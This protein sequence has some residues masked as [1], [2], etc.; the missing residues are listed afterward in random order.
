MEPANAVVTFVA[1]LAKSKRF[2]RDVQKSAPV[3]AKGPTVSKTAVE[4][5]SSGSECQRIEDRRVR[6]NPL[7]WRML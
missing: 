7:R 2:S 3:S 6:S 4:L 1:V 5:L